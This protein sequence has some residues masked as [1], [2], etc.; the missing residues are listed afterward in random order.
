[1][2]RGILTVG[3]SVVEA[4]RDPQRGLVILREAD[5]PAFA[6]AFSEHRPPP[7]PPRSPSPRGASSS[8]SS[9]SRSR[10]WRRSPARA[11]PPAHLLPRLPPVPPAAQRPRPA[12]ARPNS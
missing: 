2:E 1:M 10:S 12:P 7:S 9:Y 5:L 8:G 11:R 3:E 6:A 4:V